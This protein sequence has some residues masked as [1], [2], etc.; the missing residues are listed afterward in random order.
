MING[1]RALTGLFFYVLDMRPL[2]WLGEIM[3]KVKI[4]LERPIILTK[5]IFL[6]K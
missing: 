6:H 4:V 2:L 5:N 1:L 3:I